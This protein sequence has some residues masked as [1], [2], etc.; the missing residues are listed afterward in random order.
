TLS[1]LLLEF[2]LIAHHSA[3]EFADST[4]QLELL[5]GMVM[6]ASLAPPPS[7]G[8]RCS[9]PADPPELKFLPLLDLRVEHGGEYPTISLYPYHGREPDPLIR[10]GPGA[11]IN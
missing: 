6:S 8:N 5:D 4:I 1:M 2:A 3:I 11:P 7:R 9:G 10:P